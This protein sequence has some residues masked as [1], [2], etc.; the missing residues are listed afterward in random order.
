ML[1]TLK[2]GISLTKTQHRH[3]R[4]VADDQDRWQWVQLNPVLGELRFVRS[5]GL[6]KTDHHSYHRELRWDVDREWSTESKLWLEFSAPKFWYGHN[7]HLLYDFLSALRMLNSKLNDL[8][9]LKGRAKLPDPVYWQLYRVD[10]CYAWRFPTQ[11]SAQEYLDSLKHLHYPRKTPIVYPTSIVFVGT[12]YSLKFYLK[13]PEFRVHDLKE[14][15]KAKASLEWINHLEALAE[16]VLRCEITLR[17][18]WL[19]REGLGV[20]ADLLSSLKQMHWDSSLS[21]DESFIPEV[22]AVICLHHWQ[23]EHSVDLWQNIETGRET[24][25]A[26]GMYFA[27]P[28]SQWSLE[29]KIYCHS[30]GGFTFRV[31]DRLTALLQN[32][33][34]KFLGKEVKML[35]ANQV[36]T[37]LL[38]TY[39]PVKAARLVSLWLYVQRF[40][41]ERAKQTFG[42]NSYYR[43]KREL[44]QAG[45]SLV[46]SDKVITTVDSEFIRNFTPTVPSPHVVNAVDDFRD[47]SNILNF[48]PKTSG[49]Y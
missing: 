8:F 46:G 45:I 48:V 3:I 29:D 36:E 42:E 20:V 7:I 39:K 14:L 23:R 24:P 19:S 30:G 49:M 6:V 2:V 12:T 10:L 44:K 27:A 13:L 21:Q 37:K 4:Q 25:L 33:I 40:G 22:A 35:E 17:R 47:K 43:S 5:S 38:E 31:V 9:R 11:T 26:D 41:T 15:R 34:D 28:P 32:F 1:D 18:K 16:G